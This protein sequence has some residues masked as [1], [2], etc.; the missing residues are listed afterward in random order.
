VI[1][2]MTGFGHG[3]F[4]A[5]GLAF[6]VELRCLNH[7]YLDLRVRLPRPLAYL[8][9]QVRERLQRHFRR[10]RVDLAVQARG[11]GGGLAAL[12]VDLGTAEGYVRAAEEL[13]ERYGLPG[14]LGV[15]ELLGL[16]GV[17]RFEEPELGAEAAAAL[18]DAV[19]AAA[20]E[21]AGMRERE[22]EALAREIRERLDRVEALAG[23]LALRGE[24]VVRAWRERIRK[25]AEELAREAGAVDESRLH[26]EIV[27]AADRL[28]IAEETARI[29]SHVAQFRGI[30]EAAR[31]GAAVGRKLD[32]LLQELGR[33]A[34]TIGSKLADAEAA[35]RVV[36]LKSEIER[37]R[38]QVQNLE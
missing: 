10:G 26:Q 15:A 17:A 11:G 30:L 1:R 31:A 21:A 12:R 38:E 32:F 14:E 29:H 37:I 20:W 2:S 35:H 36:E 19:E 24:E 22:G 18:L 33:E 25:R 13:R 3:G 16:E 8:E 5:G 4:E 27:A 9:P 28:D 34:N 6:E 23:E 7:R